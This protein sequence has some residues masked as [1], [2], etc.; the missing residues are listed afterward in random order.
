MSET[1][2]PVM[3]D[4]PEKLI[5]ERVMLRPFRPGDGA[6]LW[7]AVDESRQHQLPWMPFADSQRSPVDSEEFVRKMHANWFL[8]VDI[9]FGIWERNTGRYLGLTGLI[10]IN[11]QVPS[12]EISYWLRRSAV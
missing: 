2:R 6:Q 1:V 12:F 11:W 9:M 8:R 5:G 7:E 10:R 4:V 3:V